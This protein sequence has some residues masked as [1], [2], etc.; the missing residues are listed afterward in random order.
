M[1]DSFLNI[2]RAAEKESHT[3]Y[4]DYAVFGGFSAFVEK[5]LADDDSDDALLLKGTCRHYGDSNLL[6]RKNIIAFVLR[7]VAEIAEKEGA[8]KGSEK[9][10]KP[11]KKKKEEK[12]ESAEERI[13]AVVQEKKTEAK[14]ETK[15][16]TAGRFIPEDIC[17]LKGVGPK[18]A[19]SLKKL[20]IASVEDLCEY[21]P[22]RHEDRRFL[23][24]IAS[25]RDGETALVSGFVDHVVLNRVRGNLQILK[26][27]VTDETGSLTAV[28]FNQPWLKQQLQDGGEVTIYGKAEV[29]G[30]RRGLTAAEYEL[31]RRETGFGILPVYALT[32]GI[33]QKLMRRIVGHALELCADTITE[34]LP[35]DFRDAHDLEERAEA[36]P[37]YHFPADFETLCRSRRRLVFE[38]FFLFRLAFRLRA[39][40]ETKKGIAMKKGR[41]E[42]FF[43]LLPFKPTGAQE[44]AVKEIYADMASAKMM[45]RLLEG[46]VGSGKTMVAAAAIWRCRQNGHQSA[47]MAP[48]E[49]LAGQH[50]ASLCELFKGTDLKIALLTGSTKAAEKRKLLRDLDEGR[51]DLLV[52]THALIEGAAVFRDLALVIIDEQHRFGVNQ[53]SALSLKGRDPD[54]L[55][56]TATPIPR[57]LAM[58]V[59]SDLDLSVLD[60][61]P[62]GRK[63]VKTL[64]ISDAEEERAITF[65]KKHVAAGHQC[66]V[67]CPLVEESEKLDV[68]AATAF[69]HRLR[70]KDMPDIAVGLLHGKMKA[71]EKE[72][73][74]TAFR[75]HEISV[76]V[77]TT[78]IEVG[79]DVA[80][81]TVMYI[82][83]ADRFGLAQLHQ[84]RG[85]IGR[86]EA[87]ATCILQSGS[88]S[89]LARERLRV[90]AENS[91]GFKVAERDLE[92]RGP[93][94]F[95]GV[96]QHGLPEMNL[97]DLFRDHDLLAEAAAAVDEVLAED[98][99][100]KDVKWRATKERIA[101]KFNEIKN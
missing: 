77:A 26:A 28:W 50:Y 16:E 71:K 93:G 86:S 17:Y 29:R 92:L 7:L 9:T 36:V 4:G 100:L 33:N 10:A 42:D 18:K 54:M 82:K 78:V 40:G 12:T 14:T 80:N 6:T 69:Y 66:Y 2:A 60:E 5:T 98:P 61:L 95:F 70:K 8:E 65:M 23:R 21:F 75:N 97:A 44:R 57:T 90:M 56:M 38:E 52:G 43:A 20:G 91:D 31:S 72:A 83:D 19:E 73:V 22:Y 3:G 59:F 24:D 67:V 11:E 101:L 27:R 88:D 84:I 34:F 99:E 76:L 62:P 94:D 49:I 85:R 53:R 15:K 1:K 13:P 51:I 39:Q 58:T 74:L 55:V 47:L 87:A 46:D 68:E 96:R 37:A 30:G 89:D 81:A 63:P 48:T 45:N 25:L 35:A 64:V 79:I 41:K 32:A